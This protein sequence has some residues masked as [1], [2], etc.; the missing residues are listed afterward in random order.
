MHTNTDFVSVLKKKG[1][2][3]GALTVKCQR[4]YYLE[5]IVPQSFSRAL[6]SYWCVYGKL[7]DFPPLAEGGKALEMPM[8]GCG[9][10]TTLRSP[11]SAK[12]RLSRTGSGPRESL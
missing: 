3:R 2:D 1:N 9:Q 4:K 12:R 10:M 6:G 8:S 5:G 7:C 11:N